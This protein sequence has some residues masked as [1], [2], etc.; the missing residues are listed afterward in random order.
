MK[1]VSYNVHYDNV[2]VIMYINCVTSTILQRNPK[3]TQQCMEYKNETLSRFNL[4]PGLE[5]FVTNVI[6]QF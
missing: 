1:I 6:S 4:G 3:K 2:G 5:T